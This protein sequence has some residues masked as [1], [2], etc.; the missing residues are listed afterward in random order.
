MNQCDT[1]PC[2]CLSVQNTLQ[3]NENANN[4]ATQQ[5]KAT[6]SRSLNS[7][8]FRYVSYPIYSSSKKREIPFDEWIPRWH[9]KFGIGA[10]VWTAKRN[11]LRKNGLLLSKCKYYF[12]VNSIISRWVIIRFGISEIREGY[13]WV[14]WIKQALLEKRNHK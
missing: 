6:I 5:T 8:F 2:V 3:I 4:N 1:Y 10:F 14:W 9:I 13:L 12:K 11:E 7:I